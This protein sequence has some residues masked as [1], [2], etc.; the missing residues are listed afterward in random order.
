M[1]NTAGGIVGGDRLSIELMVEGGGS[2]VSIGS[3]AAEKCYRSTGAVATI[4]IELAASDGTCLHWLPQETILFDGARLRRS[5]TIDLAPSAEFL[6][7]ET[8][9]FGRIAHGEV[10]AAGVLRDSWRVRRA[11]RLI[12]ADETAIAA[13]IDAAL[14]RKAVGGGAKAMAMLLAV[15]RD[16]EVLLEPLRAALAPFAAGTPTVESGAS[17]RDGLLLSR[18]LCAS[19][20]RLRL[21]TVA[22]VSVLRATPLPRGWA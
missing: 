1:I 10:M 7:L 3:T 8:I 19:P 12:Y 13:P 21:C 5:L 18:M 14:G 22:A 16:L 20:E 6:G 2:A 17:V 11:G 15:G 4:D 9:V